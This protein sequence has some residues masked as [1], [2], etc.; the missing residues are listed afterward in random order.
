MKLKYNIIAL[1]IASFF[2]ANLSAQDVDKKSLNLNFLLGFNFGATAPM[3]LPV[4]IRGIDSY[5]PKINPQIGLNVTYGL[6]DKWGVG[7]GITL[8]WKGMRVADHV[9]YMYTS[10]VLV[11]DG[12]KLTGYFVGKNKTNVDMTYITIPVY[13]TYSFNEKWQVKMGIYAAK[14]LS[15]KFDGDVNDGYIRIESPT[16]QKQEISGDGATFD[17]G[18]DARDYDFGMLGGGDFQLSNRIGFYGNMSWGLMPY[19]YS[20]ANPLK[21]KMHN[22]YATIGVTYRIKK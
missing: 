14:T 17:F 13:G 18:K 1:F 19:F 2:I 11:E 15:S 10:V 6:T 7:T 9:K 20:G 16:G 4:E 3:P 8:D 22:M 5:N 12:D 21:F